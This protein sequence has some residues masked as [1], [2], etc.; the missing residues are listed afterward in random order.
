MKIYTSLFAY[1]KAPSK[2]WKILKT[3]KTHNLPGSRPF[4]KKS[5]ERLGEVE[6]TTEIRQL[7][8][9]NSLNCL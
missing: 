5:R 8:D 2:Y 3:K 9:D 4:S 1:A 7:G 6:Q